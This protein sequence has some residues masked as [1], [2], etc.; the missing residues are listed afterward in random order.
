M[1][2]A[3]DR[4]ALAPLTG[5]SDVP[6]LRF[7]KSI[8]GLVPL[9]LFLGYFL[10][11]PIAS[12]ISASLH[13]NAHQLTFSLYGNLFSGNYRDAFIGS[14]KLAFYSMIVSGIAGAFICWAVVKTNGVMRTIASS[15]A[16]VLANT[17]GVPLAFMFIA[18]FGQ[19]GLITK[20]LLKVFHWD[21]YGG[22]FDLYNFWGI[23]LV[24]CFFQIPLMVIIF[25]PA[26]EN[27]RI[28]WVEA[29]ESLGGS[30][31]Q[32]FR[33]ILIPVLLPSF[34]SAC[35]LLFASAFSAFATAAAMSNGTI[36]LVPLL[37]GNLVN[38][39]VI[40][41]EANQ[42][43]ALAMGMIIVSLFVIGAYLALLR[44]TRKR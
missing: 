29:N 13:N 40:P 23:L 24:Y 42:G 19:E 38:G 35:L 12:I 9:F 26:L 31:I 20:F 3:D 44:V 14:F 15:A 4:I 6:R 39:N 30:K 1:L 10:L 18:A 8:L 17:G 27:L 21:L 41:S 33:H 5:G 7:D 16:G 11:Y 37:I 28:E 34:L 43:D 25:I 2:I 32:Y 36:P 22:S